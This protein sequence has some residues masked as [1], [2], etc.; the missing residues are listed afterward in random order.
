[1]NADREG[2]NNMENV[3][4]VAEFISTRIKHI[5]KPQFEIATECGYDKPNIIT[6]IKQGKTKLPLGKVCL[7]AKALETDPVHLLKLCL[8]EYQP[9]NWV[10]IEPLLDSTLT[11]T[12]KAL[13][14]HLRTYVGAPYLAV[15]S[16]ESNRLFSQ[17]LQSL[18][19]SA[20]F[21]KYQGD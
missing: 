20:A 4:T 19:T 5:G 3:N 6:M 7:M 15:L 8:K 14:N 2:G 11:I 17:F 10:A 13:L 12:E 18:L 1:M 16:A 9:E 21:H